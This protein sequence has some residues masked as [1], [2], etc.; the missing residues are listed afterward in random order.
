MSLSLMML[1]SGAILSLLV[2]LIPHFVWLVWS[3]LALSGACARPVYAPFGWTTLALVGALWLVLLYVYF[4]GRFQL[5]VIPTTYQNAS[6]PS[7]FDGYKIVQISDLH[8]STFDDRPSAL[9]RVVDSVNAQHPDLICFT[10]DLVTIGVAEAA[11]YTSILRQLHATDGV[12]SVLGN[13]DFMIY[14]RLTPAEQAGEVERLV[15]YQQNELGWTVLRNA[16]HPITRNTPTLNTHDKQSPQISNTDTLTIIGVDNSSCGSEGFRTIHHGDLPQALEGTDGFRILLSH[17]P[18]HWRAEVLPQTDIPLTLSGHTHSGQIRLF[19]IPL[20]SV[21]FR[22][23]AGWYTESKPSNNHP[24]NNGSITAHP[25]NDGSI[26]ETPQNN[27]STVPQKNNGSITKF[28]KNSVSIT[29]LQNNESIT[30]ISKN[31]EPLPNQL[32]ISGAADTPQRPITQSLYVNSGI[33][34]TLPIRLFCPSEIT[35]ITLR[36]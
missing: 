29:D 5:Q 28:P 8:L 27:G 31:P 1:I 10:G 35:V 24:K 30:K 11:P 2:A 7:S 36:K 3:L 15:A 12:V 4:V 26:T 16:H 9:Q 33:G 13:H 17:D 32:P 25:E 20:S 23:N 6:L 14:T 21:S 18:T 19:G 22:D 34:C